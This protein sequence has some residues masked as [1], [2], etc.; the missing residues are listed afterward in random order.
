MESPID[1]VFPDAIPSLVS[2]T[3]RIA[4]WVTVVFYVLGGFNHLMNPAV[5]VPI[6]PPGLPNPEWLSMIAGLAEITLLIAI[7]PANVY[8][9][10]ENIVID[11]KPGTGNAL[12]NWA[13]LPV[14]AFFIAW[15]WWFTRPDV[16]S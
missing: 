11:L 10:T 3:K 9:A 1:R 16:E 14:Q 8:I 6:I 7:F 4:L 2:R 5:Y 12:L 15:A 13:R